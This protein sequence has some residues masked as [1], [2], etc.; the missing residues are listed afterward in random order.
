MSW[1]VGKGDNELWICVHQCFEKSMVKYII[2]DLLYN[3]CQKTVI[4]MINIL[5]Y[6][7]PQCVLSSTNSP[8]CVKNTADHFN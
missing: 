7:I 8:N 2:Q 3:K 5:L 4:D 1:K 6:A